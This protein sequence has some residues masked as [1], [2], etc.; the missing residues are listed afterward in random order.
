MSN[1]GHIIAVERDL[2]AR[3]WTRF[4]LTGP[5]AADVDAQL[6]AFLDQCEAEGTLSDIDCSSDCPHPEH[7]ADCL[8]L[9]ID[10]GYRSCFTCGMRYSDYRNSQAG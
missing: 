5:D 7:T 10:Y 8:H 2:G 4:D 1:T 9:W 6:T 3:I